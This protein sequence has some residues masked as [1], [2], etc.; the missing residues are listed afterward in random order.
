MENKNRVIFDMCTPTAQRRPTF[1]ADIND[2]IGVV[3]CATSKDLLD[4]VMDLSDMH[5][6]DIQ[7]AIDDGDLVDPSIA[8]KIN[9]CMSWCGDPGDGSP[10]FLYC[11]ADGKVLS[12][13]IPY[14]CMEDL[15]LDTITQDEL[16]DIVKTNS[17][18][19]DDEWDDDEEEWDD[20]EEFIDDE[21]DNEEDE[22]EE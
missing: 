17:D 9:W 2:D 14:P 11:V 1:S 5:E 13:A 19:E 8:D 12:A 18:F 4:V 21:A 10:N 20:D 3:D 16:I 7:D 22:D 6:D 15:D